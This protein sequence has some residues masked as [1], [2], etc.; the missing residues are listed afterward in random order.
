MQIHG[1]VLVRA[2]GRKLV[3][4]LDKPLPTLKTPWSEL[5]AFLREYVMPKL[6]FSPKHLGCWLWTGSTTSKEGEP[7]MVVRDNFT[8]DG[9]GRLGRPQAFLVKHRIA[10]LYLDTRHTPRRRLN[11]QAIKAPDIDVVHLCGNVSCLNPNHFLVCL[12]DARHRDLEELQAK[13]LP[14]GL[15]TE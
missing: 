15:S 8:R 7:R 9:R 2:D 5:P 14:V 1:N 10:E 4:A 12:D 3:D 6:D 11:G 13:Y